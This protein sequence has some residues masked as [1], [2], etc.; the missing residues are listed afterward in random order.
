MPKS[1]SDATSAGKPKSL[2]RELMMALI[3]LISSVSVMFSVLNYFYT[4]HEAVSLYQSKL[5]DEYSDYLRQSLEWPLWTLDDELILK[6]GDAFTSNAEV[7]MLIIRDDENRTIYNHSGKLEHNQ[8]KRIV[9]INHN[10][11]HIGSVEVGIS[12]E[13]FEKRERRLLFT[14]IVGTLLLIAVIVFATRMLLRRLLGKPFDE[15]VRVIGNVADGHYNKL[16]LAVAFEEFV[17]IL[18]NFNAMSEAVNSRESSLRSSEERLKLAT[19]AGGV[20]IWDW[21]VTSNELTWDDSMYSLYGI[22]KD[23]FSGAYD[24]WI[25]TLHPDDRQFAE[26]EIQAALKNEREYAPEFRIVHPDGKIR[27]IKASSKTFFNSQGNALR[28]IGTNFDITEI[29]QAEDELRRYK[30]HLEEEIELRTADLVLARNAAEAANQA[31]SAFLANMSHELR[32]PLNAILGFSNMMRKDPLLQESQRQNLDIINRSGEHLLTLI[33]DVLEMSK[34]EAGRVQLENA[35]F[36]LGGMVRDVADMMQI[37]AQEKG[38]RLLIDQSSQFPRY[39]VGDE[40]RLRQVLINLIGNAVKFT[41]QGGVT[42]RLGTKHNKISHLQIEVEDSGPGIGLEDQKRI[43]EPFVQLGEQADSKGTGL[44]LTITR[45]FV[46][47]MGGNI[48]L[49]STIGKGSLFRVD[50][51]LNEVSEAV[52]AQPKRVENGEV[53]GL[54]PG[55]PEYRILI[56]EDQRDNQLLLTKL[57]ESVGLRVQVAENGTKGIELFQSWHPHLIWMDRRMP[58]MDGLEATRR[59][60]G[61]PGGKEVKIIAVTASAFVEQ[62]TEMLDVGMD[63][64][65]RKPYRSNEIYECLSEQL[66]V[67]YIYEGIPAQD[68][69]AMA[70]TPEM[71]SVLPDELRS[72]LTNAL[73]SLEPKRIALVIQQV[74]TYDKQLQKTLTYFAENF[75][76][77]TILKAL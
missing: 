3:V 38:L 4:R 76:Y 74:A 49:E 71:L 54:A 24:A 53:V 42:L 52:I 8:L 23:D 70:L 19:S 14:S 75:D 10:G 6:I 21:N 13:A 62:R 47:M 1:H 57:M 17:P 27:N 44:G 66:G 11:H 34:I 29:K 22:G 25:R 41:Q 48:T 65:V 15:L 32:T 51:P 55:Q 18:S 61:L 56:V 45:Q 20:G 33:N 67:R 72:D 35:P 60:R 36:D 28:M 9:T 30:D 77:P 64:F 73:E 43:F 5:S 69:P 58:V 31:K 16:E 40:A 63:D 2:Y 59:I 50:L 12:L 46:Q 39:I 68:Q 37:R 7:S 26:E